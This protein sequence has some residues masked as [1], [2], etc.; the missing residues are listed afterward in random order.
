MKKQFALA[1]GALSLIALT[2]CP[3]QQSECSTNTDCGSFQACIEGVCYAGTCANGGVTCGE[4]TFCQSNQC[5]TCTATQGCA[6]GQV[7]NTAVTG[8]AC[9]QCITD[10]QCSGDTALCSPEGTCV[11]CLGNDDCSA[12]ET[13]TA[14]ACAA[15][16]VAGASA[17]IASVRTTGS[18]PIDGA[19]VTE[20]KPAHGDDPAGFFIQ[21]EQA[22]PGLFVLDLEGFTVAVGD[23]VRLTVASTV[24]VSNHKRA[25]LSSTAGDNAVLSSGHPAQ[26]L[27]ADLSNVATWDAAAVTA[28][29]SR[30]VTATVEFAANATLGGAG[31]NHNQVQV[32]TSAY[33]GSALRV[34][35]P[36]T[37][38][39]GFKDFQGCTAEVA[40]SPMWRFTTQAQI[41]IA[42]VE[43]ITFTACPAPKPTSASAGISTEVAITFNRSLDPASVL[44]N[45][46]QFVITAEGGGTL[47]VSAVAVDGNKVILTTAAQENGKLYTVTVASTVKDAMG[48]GV[49]AAESTATF[50]GI[51]A[52]SYAKLMLNEV[53]P[54]I[55]GGKDL[56]ELYVVEAGSTGGFSLYQDATAADQV[57]LTTIPA[58]AVA[59]GDIIVVHLNTVGTASE[60]LTKDQNTAAGNYATAW[61]TYSST[62]TALT[63][64][65]RAVVLKDQ[66]GAVVDAVPFVN[67]TLQTPPGAFPAQ[68][69]AL[70]AAALWTP[71]DCGGAPCTYAST[72]TAQAVSADWT[73]TGS[74]ITGNT[75]ARKDLTDDN[76]K[77]D[78]AV[79][80][81][82]FGL[83]NVG[84]VLP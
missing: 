29:E 49:V 27:A 80:A 42:D 24:D 11:G 56:I 58:I 48:T 68:L 47:A 3:S 82:T 62:T 55:T 21:A 17:D 57:L 16:D 34:R 36:D 74:A 64:S 18:G 14:S 71:A 52:T 35:F 78:W 45:G 20:L 38:A 44:A 61:D 43:K 37:V 69:Q 23:R 46:S 66:T 77:D 81:Q 13:C 83:P 79:G 54:S 51:S 41:Q 30:L 6:E 63:Y 75:V 7:C 40:A 19:L 25:T 26:E 12:T 60:Y 39:A 59:K 33:S 5:F 1:L 4:G 84:Q 28:W 15:F 73:G 22:G 8:G 67:T 65:N 32:T 10:A 70:Q 50:R 31:A 53:N 72:P 76:N 2:G 9:V